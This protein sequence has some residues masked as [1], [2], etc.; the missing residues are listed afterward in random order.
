MNLGPRELFERICIASG[1]AAMVG[2]GNV[3]R[4]LHNVGA[5]SVEAARVEHYR[6]ALPEL[7]LRMS[8]YLP[9]QEVARRLPD[10]EALLGA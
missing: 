7:R 9:P 6:R 10:I 1:L 3:R 2:P 4:A 8:I 5:D